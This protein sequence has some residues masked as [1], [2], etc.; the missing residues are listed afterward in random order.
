MRNDNRLIACF[1]SLLSL[2][3]L[4]SDTRAQD[5]NIDRL[6][7]ELQSSDIGIRRKVLFLKSKLSAERHPASVAMRQENNIS[8]RL[9]MVR[10][11]RH[12]VFQRFP[13]IRKLCAFR[14]GRK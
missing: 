6:S 13:V 3:L 10:A 12:V 11:L 5:L 2:Y 14:T 9:E 8:I 1:V 4:V 7:L